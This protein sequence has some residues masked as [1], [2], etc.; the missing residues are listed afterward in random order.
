[1]EHARIGFELLTTKD[2]T[3][4]RKNAHILEKSNTDRRAIQKRIV[5]QILEAYENKDTTWLVAQKDTDWSVGMLG[6]CANNIVEKF[7]APTL[8]C[9]DKGKVTKCSG[10]TIPDVNLVKMFKKCGK[11]LTQYGGHAMAAGV[12]LKTKNFDSFVSAF[13][14]AVK[15]ELNNKAPQRKI[16]IEATILPSDISLELAEELASFGPF[17]KDNPLPVVRIDNV[18]LA[19]HRL[20]GK[21]SRHLKLAFHDASSETSNPISAV[22]FG[23]GYRFHD[24]IV[25]EVYDIACELMVDEWRGRKQL[26]LKIVDI[27]SSACR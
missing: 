27:Q 2:P 12:S 14:K 7:Y 22:F 13:K 20:I 11:Y 1:M 16:T 17:G 25:G 18:R 19:S 21:T 15:A 26:T 6:L 5:K 24:F 23:S 8:V 4:A 10:R 3:V 9:H